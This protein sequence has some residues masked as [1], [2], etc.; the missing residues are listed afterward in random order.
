MGVGGGVSFE[1]VDA[2]AEGGA[3]GGFAEADGNVALFGPFDHTGEGEDFADKRSLFL[4]TFHAAGENIRQILQT[5]PLIQ[6]KLRNLR[7]RKAQ[8]RLLNRLLTSISKRP[9]RTAQL[10]QN[11]P[12]SPHIRFLIIRFAF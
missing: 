2:V 9:F 12:Q 3:V 4:L 7:Y 5:R 8:Y 1:G 11:A 6:R 10:I